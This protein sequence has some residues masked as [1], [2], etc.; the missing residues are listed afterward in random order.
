MKY[1]ELYEELRN[2]IITGVYPYSARLPSKRTLADKAG[3]SVIT[4]EHALALLMDEGYIESRERSGYFVIY[5]ENRIFG[6]PERTSRMPLPH[7]PGRIPEESFPLSVLAKTMRKVLSDYGEE[8]LKKSPNTGTQ[9]LR[10]AIA[11]YLRR[12]RKMDVNP[13]RIIIGA[14]AEYL[15]SFIIQIIGRDKIYAIEDPSY[16]KIERVY[17]ANSAAFERL[18]LGNDGIKSDALQ[19]SKADVLHITP[20]RSFPSGVTASASKKR[21]YI[22]HAKKTGMIIVEDDFESEFTLSKKS[23]ETVFSLS[24]SDNVIYLNTFS[25]TVAPSVRMGYLVLPESLFDSFIKNAGFYSCTVPTF[26]QFVMARLIENGDFERH[27]NSVRRKRNKIK[28]FE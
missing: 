23:E 26:E 12:S 25:K 28:N 8:I 27:I 22:I 6:K 9:E 24:E 3:I 4:A 17:S 20:Y 13:E 1:L 7:L 14:G 10:N 16:E 2:D 19:K 18:P 5:S 21:E 11:K 15:Y